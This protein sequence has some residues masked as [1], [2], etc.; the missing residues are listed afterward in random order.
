VGKGNYV[1]VAF[2]D[3]PYFHIVR[4]SCRRALSSLKLYYDTLRK[5]TEIFCLP[6]L[7]IK[8]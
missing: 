1:G 2:F 5:S 8:I 6:Q 7:F 4:L 3:Y